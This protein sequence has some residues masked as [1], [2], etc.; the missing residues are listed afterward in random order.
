MNNA[1]ILE[2]A[3]GHRNPCRPAR[4]F[5]RGS[6]AFLRPLRT[7]CLPSI[8][9]ALLGGTLP[10][11]AMV[12]LTNATGGDLV[13]GLERYQ[14]RSGS[15]RYTLVPPQGAEETGRTCKYSLDEITAFTPLQ[16]PDRF[17]VHIDCRLEPGKDPSLVFLVEAAG[18]CHT[19]R[20]RRS[21][22]QTRNPAVETLADVTA[23]GDQ[24]QP[25][26][27]EPAAEHH[28]VMKAVE[29]VAIKAAPGQ[30]CC[31]IL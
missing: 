11:P 13:V 4:P 26:R 16:V 8:L 14:S 15:F 25:F 18:T 1:Y 20:I 19:L 17:A 10:A 7:H 28:L 3:F 2:S 27:L 21:L 24:P 5:L 29:G 31:V 22:D 6:M 9:C 30:T 12:I 23:A